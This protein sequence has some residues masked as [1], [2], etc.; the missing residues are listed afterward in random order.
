MHVTEISQLLPNAPVTLGCASS[1]MFVP[2]WVLHTLMDDS[3]KMTC[4]ISCHW[5]YVHS[6]VT[7]APWSYTMNLCEW[8]CVLKIKTGGPSG[9]LGNCV[10]KAWLWGAVRF[11]NGACLLSVRK[12]VWVCTHTH[13]GWEMGG[14]EETNWVVQPGQELQGFTHN[15]CN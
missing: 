5:R 13:N 12:S 3:G 8:M 10:Y 14:Q 2:T 7:L 6:S 9:A 11:C 4:N 1:V 15:C